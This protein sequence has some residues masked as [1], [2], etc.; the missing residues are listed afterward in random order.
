MPFNQQMT[1]P[2]ELSLVDSG[3]K[4]GPRLTA[5]PVPELESLREREPASKED[6]ERSYTKRAVLAEDLDAFEVSVWIDPGKATGFTLNLRGTNL[7]YDAAKGTLSCKDV[8]APVQLGKH[9][10]QLQILVDRGSV[11]AFAGEWRVA[12]SV[13]VI[14]DEKNRTVELIPHGGEVKIRGGGIYRMKSA[15]EK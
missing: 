4:S 9:G 8:T 7:T 13:A 10:L 12:M 3:P 11:E 6:F 5:A 2:V 15:W 14:P 1:V